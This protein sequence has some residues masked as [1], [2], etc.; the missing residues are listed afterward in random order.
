V[1][2]FIIIIIFFYMEF[3]LIIICSLTVSLYMY[4]VVN[5]ILVSL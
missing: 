1:I 4:D 2:V 5:L 3:F